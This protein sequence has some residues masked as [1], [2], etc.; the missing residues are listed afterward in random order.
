MVEHSVVVMTA[1]SQSRQSQIESSPIGSQFSIQF[2]MFYENVFRINGG[3]GGGGIKF[4]YLVEDSYTG[5][6]TSVTVSM[7]YLFA[8]QF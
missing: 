8:F 4:L 6:L 7:E 2:S 1:G 3:G 5:S